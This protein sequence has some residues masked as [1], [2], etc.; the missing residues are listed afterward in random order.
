MLRNLWRNDNV[1]SFQLHINLYKCLT[2]EIDDKE[3]KQDATDNKIGEGPEIEKCTWL[4]LDGQYSN[5]L[6]L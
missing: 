1:H 3:M 2:D 6:E 5:E 4:A